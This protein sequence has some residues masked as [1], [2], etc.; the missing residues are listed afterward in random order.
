MYVFIIKV[1]IFFIR[2]ENIEQVQL[3]EQNVNPGQKIGPQDFE[4]NK[5][6]GEGG[7][8]KVF[9]VRKLTGKDKGNIF[10]MKVGSIL[11]FLFI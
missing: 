5:I 2:G 11:T 3:T 1:I 8:G 9:Q 7:Y 4:L 10:A 6:L